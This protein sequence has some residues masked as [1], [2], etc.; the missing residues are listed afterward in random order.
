MMSIPKTNID[1]KIKN[2]RE[3]WGAVD[4]YEKMKTPREVYNLFF[5]E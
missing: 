5:E 2:S 1:E 3:V 4:I